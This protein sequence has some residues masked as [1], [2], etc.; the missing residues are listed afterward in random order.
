MFSAKVVVELAKFN[1]FIQAAALI[2]PSLVTVDDIKGTL[3]YL[4]S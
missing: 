4:N 3:P 1:N 2:H